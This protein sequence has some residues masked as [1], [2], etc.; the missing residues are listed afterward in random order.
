MSSLLECGEKDYRIERTYALTVWIS[1]TLCFER[2]SC[3]IAWDS[4][5]KVRLHL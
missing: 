5:V 1:R 4:S 3:S 2:S